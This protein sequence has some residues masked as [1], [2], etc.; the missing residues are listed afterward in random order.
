[1]K[2]T[3][4][5]AIVAGLAFAG[6]AAGYTAAF[7]PL[8]RAEPRQIL[9][10]Y[11]GAEDCPPCKAW[12]AGDGAR[13]R[14]S[15]EFR[16]VSYRQVLSPSLFDVLK[17]ENWP[18]DLVRYRPTIDHRSGVPLWLIVADGDVVMQSFGVTQWRDA[19]LPRIKSLVH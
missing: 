13:F 18:D 3:R 1:M 16:R 7:A 2:V 4:A 15:P 8:Q 10:L 17:D 19:V 6:L 14:D 9:L 5:K 11:V 12:Q